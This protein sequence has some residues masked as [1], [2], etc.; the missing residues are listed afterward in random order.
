MPVKSKVDISQTFVAFSENMN[1]NQ[2]RGN[3]DNFLLMLSKLSTWNKE[4]HFF[5]TN[6]DVY[7]VVI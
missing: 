3:D 2:T 7:V 6:L 1:F 4:L 5:R